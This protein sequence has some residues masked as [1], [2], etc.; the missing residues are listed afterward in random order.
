[1]TLNV[2]GLLSLK[3]AD[4]FSVIGMNEASNPD[5]KRLLLEA[6]NEALLKVFLSKL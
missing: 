4:P 2:E 1:M 3:P 5:R 6:M